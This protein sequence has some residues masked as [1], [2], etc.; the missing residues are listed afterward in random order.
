MYTVQYVSLSLCRSLR[1]D[2]RP[3]V[4]VSPRAVG[5][6]FERLLYSVGGP[7]GRISHAGPRRGGPEVGP[8]EEEGQHELRQDGTGT[9]ILLRQD[10]SDEGAR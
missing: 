2:A 4:A 9:S 6:R 5:R 10:D 3:V 8:E 7:R 1:L